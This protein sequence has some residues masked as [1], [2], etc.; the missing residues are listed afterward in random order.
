MRDH[1][2]KP[3]GNPLGRRLLVIANE[4]AE[5]EPLLRAVSVHVAGPRTGRVL[6]VAPAANRT[7]RQSDVARTAVVRR[8]QACIALLAQAGIDAEGMIGDA[9]PVQAIEDVLR[10]FPADRLILAL[11]P[12][13]RSAA[14]D[15]AE[16]A[17][18]RFALPT[19][20]LV[21]DVA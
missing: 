11:L 5:S 15:V 6:V 7:L 1:T 20:Q 10:I 3:K 13:E 8:L 18:A 12:R 4:A 19:T 21:V 17:R 16:R 14:A 9:D 2:R